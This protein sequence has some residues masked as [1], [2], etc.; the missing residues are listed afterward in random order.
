LRSFFRKQ[1]HSDK[2]SIGYLMV[3]G[4]T[5]ASVAAVVLSPID[6]IKILLLLQRSEA[7]KAKSEGKSTVGKN[8]QKLYKGPMD[9][10]REQK[11]SGLFRGFGV[12]LSREAVYGAVYFSVFEKLK[13]VASTAFSSDRLPFPGL[14]LCGGLS[15]SIMWTLIFP[16]DVIKTKVQAN[17]GPPISVASVVKSHFRAEG[18]GGFYKGL[19][20]AVLRSF[21]AHGIVLATYTYMMSQLQQT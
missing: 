4:M 9:V 2:L 18:I 11:F 5:S 13:R 17:R 15:G 19:S 7:E 21:P 16:L 10:I 8:Q 12:A 20:A 1:T 6:R 14:V 3:C